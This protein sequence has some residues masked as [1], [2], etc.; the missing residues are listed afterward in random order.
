MGLFEEFEEELKNKEIFMASS[1]HSHGSS[2]AVGCFE[3][4]NRRAF[5]ILCDLI[6]KK[7]IRNN[8]LTIDELPKHSDS[9]RCDT[10]LN[11]S[12]DH[13]AVGSS[14]SGTV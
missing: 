11:G 9:I 6:E 8:T 7:Y 2:R 5:K 1:E 3:E 10:C 13:N 14:G 12:H 4:L